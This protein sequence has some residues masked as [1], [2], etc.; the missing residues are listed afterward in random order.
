[1]LR[2][3]FVDCYT[4]LLNGL[5]NGLPDRLTLRNSKYYKK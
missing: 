1:M 3:F 5:F 4:I 2:E